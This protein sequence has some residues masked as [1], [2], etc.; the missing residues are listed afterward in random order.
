M[1]LGLDAADH[2]E[3]DTVE[4]GGDRLIDSSSVSKTTEE[5]AREDI[6]ARP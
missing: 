4:A 5:K 2:I 3:A 1:W 6:C